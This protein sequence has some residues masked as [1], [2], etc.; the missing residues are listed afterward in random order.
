MNKTLKSL[1]EKYSKDKDFKNEFDKNKEK[2]IEKHFGKKALKQLQV[3]I[4]NVP[5]NTIKSFLNS[6][7]ELDDMALEGIA[8]GKKEEKRKEE[9]IEIRVPKIVKEEYKVNMTPTVKGNLNVT[10]GSF[11]DF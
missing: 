2:A 6:K 8:G 4:E 10:K 7:E 11:T 3:N 1:K 5:S 9:I